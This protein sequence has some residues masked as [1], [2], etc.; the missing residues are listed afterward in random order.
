MAVADGVVTTAFSALGAA[1]PT[2][3][4]NAT[5]LL[6]AAWLIERRWLRRQPAR[7]ELLWRGAVLASLLSLLPLLPLPWGGPGSDAT[8]APAAARIPA[9]HAPAAVPMPSATQA[10][11]RASATDAAWADSMV[12]GAARPA[13]A[14]PSSSASAARRAA[15]TGPLRLPMPA[16]LQRALGVAWMAGCAASL[17]LLALAAVRVRRQPRGAPAPAAARAL[18]AQLAA[19]FGMRPPRLGTSSGLCS[20]LALPGAAIVLPAWALR[21]PPAQL[22]AMLAHELWHLR[23]RD[24]RWRVLHRLLLAPLFFHPFA[25]LAR[26]RLDAL[27]ES[28]CDAAAAAVAGSGRPLAQCLAACIAHA[29]RQP[30]PPPPRLALAMTNRPGAVVH[31]VRHL[32]EET[33]PM[34]AAVPS[35]WLRA[36]TL[37]LA[38]AAALALPAISVTA[39]AGQDERRNISV[40]VDDDGHQ[41]VEV[42]ISGAGR[43]IDVELD[44]RVQFTANEDDVAALGD[45]DELDISEARDGVLRRVLFEGADGRVQRTAWVDGEQRPF[46]RDTSAWLAALLPQVLRESGI[47]AE[48]RAARLLQRGGPGALLDEIGLIESDHARGIYLAVLLAQPG[49]QPAQLERALELAA[50]MD[51]DFE[52]RRA[53]QRVL[54]TQSLDASLLQRLLQLALEIES[55]FERAE[56]LRGAY[57]AITDAGSRDAWQQAV[58][59]LGSDFERRR[60][61]EGVLE[62]GPDADA[63][64]RVLQAAN[65][66]GSD[67]ELRTLLQL[68]AGQLHGD[69]ALQRAWH[70]AA[71]QLGS[72]FE[73]RNA[74]LSFLDA[75]PPDL[76]ASRAVLESASG[77]GSDFETLQV[78]RA[79]AAVMPA[80]AGLI[81]EYRA[82]ARRL[83]AHERG[84]AEQALDRFAAL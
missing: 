27:A 44:G 11:M 32:L 49:L 18:T 35:R 7:A 66:F 52:L 73:R 4:C 60:V 51:S 37:S 5:L 78:L 70:A 21:L 13:R 45:G 72:D 17:V 33:T 80:D 1:L 62:A 53:L 74:L 24:P 56:L 42:E 26:R 8:L 83:S 55:D 54:A 15:A 14:T 30:T 71:Q 2:L 19:R 69:P 38:I 65:S 61:L 48:G 3:A 10:A 47:D 81:N 63:V 79:L 36:G 23:R 76:A 39:V 40:L 34:N 25:W 9:A 28:A 57:P 75:V 12:A 59:D 41:R 68:A 82:L 29:Q 50:A 64:A 58:S 16:A 43:E 22:Q 31:R 46:D 20:A 67:F 84:Q 6:G 77:I